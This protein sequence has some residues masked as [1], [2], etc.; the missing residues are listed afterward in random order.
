MIMNELAEQQLSVLTFPK[1]WLVFV[2]KIAFGS[3]FR[4]FAGNSILLEL[5][6]CPI[7]AHTQMFVW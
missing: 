7:L 6:F 1:I 4:N 5:S 3:L 2:Q